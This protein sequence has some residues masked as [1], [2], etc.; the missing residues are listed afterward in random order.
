MDRCGWYVRDCGV[1]TVGK[2]SLVPQ[3][4]VGMGV[5]GGEFV[6][7]KCVTDSTTCRYWPPSRCRRADVGSAVA[8]SLS[9]RERCVVQAIQ[10]LAFMSTWNECGRVSEVVRR[11]EGGSGAEGRPN[12]LARRAFSCR[13]VSLGKQ[14]ARCDVGST[15]QEPDTPAGL[16][17]CKRGK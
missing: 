13:T 11:E 12:V 16:A 8:A 2:V 9:Y 14:E 17:G 3:L 7:T 15:E 10:L 5:I 6:S 4:G 1:F